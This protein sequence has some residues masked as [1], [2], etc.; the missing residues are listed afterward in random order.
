MSKSSKEV[1]GI[2][3]LQVPSGKANPAPPIGPA[4]GQKGL[5]IMEF[6]KQFNALKFDYEAGTPIPVTITAYK[7]K[8]FTFTTKNPPV[9]FLIMKEI[10]LEKG[11]SAPGK[12]SAGKI[13]MTQIASVAKKKMVDMNSIDLKACMEMVKGS[14]ISMGL[15]VVE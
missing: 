13:N 7:D 5:N 4:L 8:S 12:D 15:E 3:K 14:A 6:C 10:K 1:L 2:I 11:S 9:S